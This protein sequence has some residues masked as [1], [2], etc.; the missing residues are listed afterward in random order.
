MKIQ[1][2]FLS[3]YLTIG[4]LFI[5]PVFA[6]AQLPDGFSDEIVN[7]VWNFPV[8]ITFSETGQCFI[9]EKDGFV[10]TT[11]ENLNKLP[12]PVIDIQ[13]EVASYLDHGLIGFVL[14]PK[15][16]ENGYVY[17]MYIVDRH[18]LL[19]FGTDDYDPSKTIIDEAT[20]GRIT[21]FTLDKSTDFTATMPNSRH[22]VLGHDTNDG[23]PVI[24]ASHGAG[25]L[26]FG[27][28]GSLLASFGDQGSFTSP[29]PGSHPDTDF[30]QALNDGIISEKEDVGAFKSQ[31]IDNLNGKILRID[32]VTGLGISSDADSTETDL[33][34][35]RHLKRCPPGG[36]RRP[37]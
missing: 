8:G 6:Y 12:I 28:D 25:S 34:P 29:D 26:V 24:T 19:Y 16:G 18:H 22:I 13:E 20:I 21:R 31:L 14:D 9:W 4:F 3:N 37:L 36:P 5:L 17:L 33:F 1:I 10:Y 23:I 27:T 30:Q 2:S 35:L 7:D 11:D 15:F 32:P